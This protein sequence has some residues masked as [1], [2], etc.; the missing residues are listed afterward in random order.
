[1]VQHGYPGIRPNPSGFRAQAHT[2]S[3]T[4]K[5]EAPLRPSASVSPDRHLTYILRVAV[6]AVTLVAPAHGIELFLNEAAPIPVVPVLGNVPDGQFPD[7][8]GGN[9]GI[10]SYKDPTTLLGVSLSAQLVGQLTGTTTI[11]PPPTFPSNALVLSYETLSG[12]PTYDPFK[13]GLELFSQGV[14]RNLQVVE[15]GFGF[16]T[17]IGGLLDTPDEAH[18]ALSLLFDYNVE[19]F[20]LD[21]L[22]ANVEFGN[23]AVGDP[24]NVYFQFFDATGNLIGS[25]VSARAYD[26]PLW[27]SS[28]GMPFRALSITTDDYQGIGYHSFRFEPA[29]SPEPLHLT[30][31]G[32]S[33]LLITRSRFAPI[34]AGTTLP[35]RPTLLPR[36][37]NSVRRELPSL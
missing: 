24:G 37:T 5:M 23:P 33:L 22:G 27:F 19:V 35:A 32:L 31:L 11:D 1:M 21:M 17:I 8:S 36:G 14:H 2:D 15:I 13:G 29:T 10:I 30:M 25:T 6:V 28:L 18:G 20:G 3:P 9:P 12:T 16:P 7:A 4:R 26:G 34:L